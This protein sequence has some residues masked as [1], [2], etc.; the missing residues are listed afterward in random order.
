[1]PRRRSPEPPAAHVAPPPAPAPK[2]LAEA[3]LLVRLERKV[4]DEFREPM[5]AR[6]E[7]LIAAEQASL[8]GTAPTCERCGRKMKCRGQKPCSL[9]S[10]FG[11]V[12]LRPSLY[13]CMPCGWQVRPLWIVLGVERGQITGGLARLLALLGVIVPYEMA[14]QLAKELL[15]VTVCAMT[16]WREVQRLGRACEAYQEQATGYYNDPQREA[17]PLGAPGAGEPPEAVVLAPDGCTLGMQVRTTRRRRVDGQPLPPLPKVEEG[18]FREVKTGVLLLP[19]ERLEPSPGRK[20][21]V[22][23]MLVTCLGHADELFERVSAKLIELNWLGPKTVIVIVGD[24]AE[25]IWKRA[26]LF[27]NRCEILDFWHAIEKAWEFARCQYGAESKRADQFI[28]RLA[29]D[30][31]AGSISDVLVR[32]GRLEPTSKEAG[33]KLAAVLS[34]YTDNQSRM[35][36]DEYLR[37]GY[38]IGSG[39]VESAH[40]Q[41]VHARLRQAGMRF[42]EK[43]AQHLLALRVLLLNGQWSLLD[44][45]AM[46]PSDQAA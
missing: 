5:R 21:V 27:A 41:V 30:L 46:Q 19:T 10:E 26:A 12:K 8:K 29:Q 7:D 25:W 3:P 39:A 17:A 16:V 44:R 40:K 15:G 23:R 43:G 38:G 20:S 42:S 45:L 2:V 35:H 9:T 28:H 6:L 1:M 24:G 4:Q 22:R 32:L 34:Y 37:H 31:R 33:E 14:A 11:K 36:Y 18:Q 13:R